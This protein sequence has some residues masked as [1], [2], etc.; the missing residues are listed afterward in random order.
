MNPVLLMRVRSKTD[1]LFLSIQVTQEIPRANY[2]SRNLIRPVSKTAWGSCWHKAPLWLSRMIQ[3]LCDDI[4]VPESKVPDCV[5][6]SLIVTTLEQGLLPGD[7]SGPLRFLGS[8]CLKK[9]FWKKRTQRDN[10]QVTNVF[11]C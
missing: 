2:P 1:S 11:L 4:L 10:I 6:K 3:C 7:K 8:K 9:M 5:H